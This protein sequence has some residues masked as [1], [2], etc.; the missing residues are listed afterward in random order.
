MKIIL[1]K[2]K[3]KGIAI[4]EKRRAINF[5]NEKGRVDDTE[6]LGWNIFDKE[7]C[8]TN[9]NVTIE[10]DKLT[11]DNVVA[12]SYLI[13]NVVDFTPLKGIQISEMVNISRVCFYKLSSIEE[14]KAYYL[15]LGIANKIKMQ[16][17]YL[18]FNEEQEI[19]VTGMVIEILKKHMEY[20]LA[21][22]ENVEKELVQKW[23][24]KNNL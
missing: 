12:L 22:G 1:K 13:R 19:D 3:L 14:T 23:I 18:D 7:D 10:I 21:T 16:N 4:V 2:G 9:K 15:Y 8:P 11:V 17:E 20:Y 5:Y 6:D 24:D